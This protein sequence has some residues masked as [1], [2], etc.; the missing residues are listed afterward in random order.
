MRMPDYEE[1]KKEGDRVLEMIEKEIKQN[2]LDYVTRNT[3]L[4]E[5]KQSI[6]ESLEI[7]K[8]LEEITKE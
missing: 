4:K 2:R 8:N 5:M 1:I 6:I 7:M 3:E